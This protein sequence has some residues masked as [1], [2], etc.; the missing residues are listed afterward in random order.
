MLRPWGSP[1]PYV[2]GA[3]PPVA[4]TVVEYDIPTT[5]SGR[6]VVTMETRPITETAYD[7]EA[8]CPAES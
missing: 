3:V 8:V 6:L 4:A 1:T 5:P 7:C 2:Y